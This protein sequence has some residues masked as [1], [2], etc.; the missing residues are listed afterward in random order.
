M[1][2]AQPGLWLSEQ[3][4]S[5]SSRWASGGGVHTPDVTRS[6]RSQGVPGLPPRT[7]YRPLSAASESDLAACWVA[8]GGTAWVCGSSFRMRC[9]SIR[10]NRLWRCPSESERCGLRSTCESCSEPVTAD[11]H[12]DGRRHTETTARQRM[13]PIRRRQR[14]RWQT[15]IR[16]LASGCL[17]QSLHE[18]GSP[19]VTP[20]WSRSATTSAWRTHRR[21]RVAVD[22]SRCLE[23]C[24][25]VGQRTCCMC[26]RPIDHVWTA[27]RRTLA[28]CL[29]GSV[30]RQVTV[31]VLTVPYIGPRLK[32]LSNDK[33]E[34]CWPSKQNA[35]TSRSWRSV[36]RMT[37]GMR[38]SEIS[39]ERTNVDA[40]DM[41]RTWH[42]NNQ[43]TYWQLYEIWKNAKKSK[44]NV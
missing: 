33:T 43:Q 7:G 14:W 20:R 28:I 18:G 42:K 26:R 9:W 16:V 8:T 44:N 39:T 15:R 30:D 19:A 4:S 40:W 3:Q 31:Y 41:A 23:T 34:P 29:T 35:L 12:V 5:G 38:S 36:Y 27:D 10:G 22:R 21:C 13:S 25:P 37:A 2:I 24:W 11:Q 17:F 1:W 32:V 6:L